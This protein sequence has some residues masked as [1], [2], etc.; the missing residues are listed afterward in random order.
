MNYLPVFLDIKNRPC[1]VVGGGPIALRK[2]SL[3]VRAQAEITVIAPE[4]TPEIHDLTRDG[5]VIWRQKHFSA[6]DLN[7][8]QLV[9]AATDSR[10]VNA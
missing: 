5:A 1:L 3:L 8:Y 10:K 6:E 4:I 9:M 2:I 7:D